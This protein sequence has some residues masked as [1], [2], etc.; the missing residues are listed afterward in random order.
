MSSGYPSYIADPVKEQQ[1]IQ[2]ATSGGGSSSSGGSTGGT[3]QSDMESAFGPADSGIDYEDPMQN[4]GVADTTRDTWEFEFY[5]DY[6][7][8]YDAY[9]PDAADIHLLNKA[10]G[11]G[12]GLTF[13]EVPTGFNDPNS[14]TGVNPLM[15]ATENVGRDAYFFYQRAPEPRRA[16][17]QTLLYK[18]GLVDDQPKGGWGSI[19]DQDYL[20]AWRL[21]VETSQRSGIPLYVL[22]EQE[23]EAIAAM[24]GPGGGRGRGSGSGPRRPTAQI[25]SEDDARAIVDEVAKEQL[26]RKLSDEEESLAKGIVSAIRSKMLGEANAMIDQQMAGGGSASQPTNPRVTAEQEIESRREDEATAYDLAK[27]FANLVGI[28][29]GS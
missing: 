23:A 22:L 25:I 8:D 24:G 9:Q 26:G 28:T 27:A 2:Q 21:A 19:L 4:Y 3:T 29:G 14:L 6:A 17:L 10:P 1:T 11:G 13:D 18:A 5:A 7:F 12:R 15:G 16:Y 20:D